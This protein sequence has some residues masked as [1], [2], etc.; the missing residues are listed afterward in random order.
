MYPPHILLL[1]LLS[2]YLTSGQVCKD[3]W[4]GT[5]PGCHGAC[6]SRTHVAIRQDKCGDGHCCWT[7]HKVYCQCKVNPNCQD[8]WDGTAPFCHGECPSGWQAVG[9]SSSGNGA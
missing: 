1:F 5:A 8:F 3:Y 2:S 7:G 6:D 9:A 4:A